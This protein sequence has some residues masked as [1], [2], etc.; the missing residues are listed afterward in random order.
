MIMNTELQD[1]VAVTNTVGIDQDNIRQK[2]AFDLVSNTSQSFF[3]TGRA[4]TGKTTF[5]RNIQK[6]VDKNFIVVAPTGIAAIIV[7]GETIHS[8][9]KL[10]LEVQGPKD[11][12]G[13]FT[14]EQ[15][16]ALRSCDTIIV[17]EVSMVRCD[18]V[19]AVDRTLQAIMK[20]HLPF[21]GKQ[22]IFSGDV[23]QLPPVL[24]SGE[25]T[26]A[27]RTYYG[28][29][30]PFF[31][32]AHVFKRMSLPIIEFE[33][34]YRQDDKEFLTILNHIREG[35]CTVDELEVLNS[36]CGAPDDDVPSV[37]SLSPFKSVAKEINDK[38]LAGLSTEQLDYEG[39]IE[40]KFANSKSGK[41]L[42]ETLPAP[43]TLSLK[44][45]AQVM[46]TRN[47]SSRRWVNGTIGIIEDLSKDEIKVRVGENIY[48]VEPVIWES[49]EYKFDKES[50][51]M[52]KEVC[53][54]FCQY[55]LRL[56][57]AVTIHKSQ[58]LTFD[59]M[60]LD[61]SRGTFAA[62]QLYVALSR[63][64]SL[65]G[66][67]LSRAISFSDIKSDKDVMRF[68]ARFNDDAKINEQIL[69]GEQLYPYQKINDYDG[70]TLKYM[71][72][73][74]NALRCGLLTSACLL[75]KKMFSVMIFDDVLMGSCS[76]VKLVDEDTQCAHY[77]NSVICLYGNKPEK[78][79][80][81]ID[82]ILNVR[83]I[84]EAYYIKSRALTK[85]SRYK[86]ADVVNS[87]MYK[88]LKSENSP[89]YYSFI[90]TAALVNKGIGDS[91]LGLYKL[92]VRESP[93]YLP[94][95][96][97]FHEEMRA[98]NKNL[99]VPNNTEVPTLVKSFNE[100]STTRFM[101]NLRIA[102]DNNIKEVAKLTKVI[103]SQI[104]K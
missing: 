51:K 52:N 62:G 13:R 5:L 7:G 69:E 77:A 54:S 71:E 98:K 85:L 25:E 53:G 88:C 38:R 93:D 58:G 67:Y 74:L 94:G 89:L 81:Y 72:L 101:Q 49:Y 34:V 10:S 79:I 16:L 36:R 97:K 48:S 15:Y 100:D 37:I 104:L 39:S 19:D 61:L 102:K 86:E 4:G 75:F 87:L 64:K 31:F 3:L 73:A 82:K 66:L 60:V 2:Q 22:I 99:M 84:Y 47:D 57:W 24:R 96:K 91:Y 14:Q 6:V 63:V 70:M 1:A 50:K 12:G 29:D 11:I 56:A 40:G 42:D 92:L 28:T 45:G 17:D 35:V 76:D 44:K 103:E 32:N 33:K 41:S 59:R 43:M 80:E 26:E 21:G 46:F 18:I 55:P 30:T 83:M 9:F 8:R 65:A 27:M 23:F 20:N 78:A 95:Y 90:V 68:A